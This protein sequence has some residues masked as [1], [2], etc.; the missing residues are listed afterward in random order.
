MGKEELEKEKK[1]ILSEIMELREDLKELS[2]MINVIGSSVSFV[3][4]VI[5]P[6]IVASVVTLI[7]SLIGFADNKSLGTFIIMF[8]ISTVVSTLYNRNIVKKRKEKLIEKR[9]DLQRRLVKK[10][11]RLADIE[12]KLKD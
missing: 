12:S 1:D 7:M 3:H 2:D 8:I 9:L 11:Q 10:S 4:F 5:L 6:I